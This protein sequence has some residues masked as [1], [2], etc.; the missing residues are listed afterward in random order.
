MIGSNV[1]SVST[2]VVQ[3]YVAKTV[4]RQSTWNYLLTGVACLAK[5]SNRR[6]YFIQ[7]FDMDQSQLAWEQEVYREFQFKMSK[8]EVAIFEADNSMAALMFAD[9][10]EAFHFQNAVQLR[11]SKLQ[12]K[13]KTVVNVPTNLAP[14]ASKMHNVNLTAKSPKMNKIGAGGKS[15]KKSKAKLTLDDIGKPTNFVHIQGSKLEK[16]GEMQ[17]VNNLSEIEPG[18]RQIFQMAGLPQSMMQD[19]QKRKELENFAKENA[20]TLRR[21]SRKPPMNSQK[22]KTSQPMMARLDEGPVFSGPPPPPPPPPPPAPPAPPPALS[23]PPPPPQPGLKPS[24]PTKPKPQPVPDA[25]G[26][27]LDAIGKF[28]KGQLK[29]VEVNDANTP[30][31]KRKSSHNDGSLTDVLTEAIRRHESNMNYSDSE[32]ED[33]E[34]DEVWSDW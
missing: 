8:P 12:Q 19:P 10:N 34:D 18:M 2:T 1:Q 21:M 29:P 4:G 24:I 11:L 16:G 9:V 6:S 17:M 30:S 22:P 26:G 28:Q 5:D 13:A 31:A 25:R 14:P 7:V 20:K 23:G 33:E 3:L 15:K 32:D 27:L